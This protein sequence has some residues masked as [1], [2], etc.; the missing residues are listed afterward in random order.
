[1]TSECQSADDGMLVSARLYFECVDTYIFIQLLCT[2]ERWFVTSVRTMSVCGRPDMGHRLCDLLIV[3]SNTN[4]LLCVNMML[5]KSSSSVWVSLPQFSLRSLSP[6]FIILSSAAAYMR[7][8]ISVLPFLIVWVCSSIYSVSLLIHFRLP[9][10]V[11]L[12]ANQLFDYVS[13]P[14]CGR[15]LRRSPSFVH[16][17]SYPMVSSVVLLSMVLYWLC[18]Y[19]ICISLTSSNCSMRIYP[20]SLTSFFFFSLCPFSLVFLLPYFITTYPF[21]PVRLLK[22]LGG[23]HACEVAEP[24]SECR[25]DFVTSGCSIVLSSRHWSDREY[26]DNVCRCVWCG[27]S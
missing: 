4:L 20:H 11:L 19:S 16:W 23:V 24:L 25:Q 15:L 21:K 8:G 26:S 2:T 6:C 18:F 27:M 10:S 22:W 12:S 1:M 5:M 7:L 14:S 3:S 9:L 17:I 13:L